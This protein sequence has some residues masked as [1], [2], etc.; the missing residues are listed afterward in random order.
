MTLALGMPLRPVRP[1]QPQGGPPAPVFIQPPAIDGSGRIGAPLT[2]HPGTA[3]GGTVTAE[4]RR[5]AAVL[6]SGVTEGQVYVP[7][8]ADDLQTLVLAATATGPG[9][10]VSQAASVAVTWPAPVFATE[11]SLGGTA[12][13]AGDTVHL[14]LGAT[15]VPSA[16]SLDL[17][18][19]DGA[20][21]SGEL[22]GLDWDSAGE[23]GGELALRARAVNSGG[24][25]LSRTVT[26]TLAPAPSAAALPVAPAA[27][28][29]AGLAVTTLSGGRVQSATGLSGPTVTAGA[30]ALG[31]LAMTDP[32]GR[33]FWRFEGAEF[34]DVPTSFV[35]NT[36]DVTVFFVGRMHRNITMNAIL[37]LGNRGAGTNVS[38]GNA[39][40]D[41][42]LASNGAPSVR[43]ASRAGTSDAA[44]AA[45][46]IAGSQ[47][48]VLGACSRT[49]A[50]GGMRLWINTRA[51]ALSQTSTAV[52][53]A[54][55]EIG[56][57]AQ[58]GTGWGMFDLYELV[59]FDRGL[60]NAEGDAVAA[61]LVA[62]WAIPALEHQIV[63]EGD[64]ITQGTGTVTSGQS[65]GMVLSEPGQGRIPANWRVVNMASSGAQVSNLVTRRDAATGWPL[66]KL[67]GQNVLAFEIGR[68]DMASQTETQHYANVVAYLNTATTGV[69][70]RGWTVRVMANIASAPT[71]QARIDPYRALLR[72]PQFLTDVGAGAGG[73]HEGR[74]SV[75]STD[76]ITDQGQS[77][78]LDSTD[79]ADTTY[80]QG[81][82]THPGPLGA[83]LRVSGGDD[84]ALGIGYGL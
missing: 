63:L 47:M 64:S 57:N 25:T 40:L 80:Y 21:R 77:V 59:V 1:A 45:W 33:S 27:R 23:P 61:A 74:V 5:G 55:A 62:H 53:P 15:D 14:A 4:L 68:N 44:N 7:V 17:F 39:T 50:N 37:S 26:A 79:A 58:S 66:Y 6:V 51:A 67:P 48:Q 49:T 69:L 41:V 36:R 42:A 82:T 20:D 52:A 30:G 60:T 2:L 29:H 71:L 24:V 75:L 56:R 16:L 73:P 54:G 70:Q 38:T 83:R 84:P 22:A 65:A 35:A 46:M 32:L 72:A 34:L 8:A 13:T 28:W 11:P 78:F 19:L 3:S 43:C 76:R 18:T 81:D 10:S 9:G 31:P 12:F